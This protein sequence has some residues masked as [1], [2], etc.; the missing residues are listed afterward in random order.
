MKS[1]DTYAEVNTGIFLRN[2]FEISKRTNIHVAPVLK[3]DAYGHGAVKLAQVCEQ[4]GI[5][6]LVVAFLEEA[7]EIRESGV[8]L[9]ILVLNYFDPK[10]AKT[11]L[12]NDLSVTIFSKDQKD[13]ISAYLDENDKLKVHLKVDTGM[14]RLGP[15]AN[16]AFE[17]YDDIQKDKRFIFEGIYTHFS[18]AD[19]PSDVLNAHQVDEFNEFIKKIKKP[20]YVH[21]S[22]SAAATCLDIKVGNFSRIGIA[23][24]GL[25]PSSRTKI[26]YLEPVMSVHSTVAFIKSIDQGRTIGYG[27]TFTADKKM[28]VATVPFG[29]ADG[30]PR[31]LSNRGHV[32]LNGKRAK[33][34]GRISMDQ[35]VIDVSN[36]EDVK[37]G[38]DVVIIGKSGKDEITAEEIAELAGTINYEIVCGIS[39]R[40]PRIY[41]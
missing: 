20:K 11:A 19:D 4:N 23:A 29:Y 12:F 40:V 21:I 38:D 35:I 41:I 17:L 8:L 18:A 6:F 3:A 9:P 14:G 2:I 5:G 27:H 22:N 31:S 39:K 16:E 7:I 30:L 37:I 32:L 34:L 24:Y 26:D 36:I 10:Y 28:K 33:I 1:R 25:Q 15:T 13:A